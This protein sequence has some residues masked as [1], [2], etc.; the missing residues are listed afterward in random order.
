MSIDWQRLESNRHIDRLAGPSR[1]TASCINSRATGLPS[2][3]VLLTA[4]ELDSRAWRV[5]TGGSF[6]PGTD[7]MGWNC[8][9]TL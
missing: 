8:L 6:D 7:T 9:L 4:H 3:P 1:L 2:T 5:Y